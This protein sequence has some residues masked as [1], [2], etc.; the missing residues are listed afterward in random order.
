MLSLK[1]LTGWN[2][3]VDHDLFGVQASEFYD[4]PALC[5]MGRLGWEKQII[6]SAD[7]AYWRIHIEVVYEQRFYESLVGVEVWEPGRDYRDP[8]YSGTIF[9]D[10][11][12]YGIVLVDWKKW[13]F[14]V[15]QSHERYATLVGV[16]DLKQ[17][18]QRLQPRFRDAKIEERLR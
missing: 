10:P 8:T 11:N 2:L 17:Y 18:Y 15:Y 4:S 3:L 5:E 7:S 12:E 6:A 14:E 1:V 13:R 9:S 16:R